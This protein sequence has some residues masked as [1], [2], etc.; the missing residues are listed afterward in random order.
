VRE[1]KQVHLWQKIEH[2][3]AR[4]QQKWV[5]LGK[6]TKTML[7]RYSGQS[8]VERWRTLDNLN[9]NWDTRT[10]MLARFV[11]PNCSVIEFGAGRC[12]LPRY[13]PGGCTYT[14]SDL[15]DRGPGTIICDLN[16]HQL[17]EFPWHDVALF[18][19]VLEYVHDLDRLVAHLTRSCSLIAAS[20][21]ATDYPV[22]Q[23]V[24]TRRRHGWVNDYQTAELE[25]LF[26]HHGFRCIER[27]LWHTHPLFKFENTQR[28]GRCANL[29]LN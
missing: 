25:Q 4:V 3:S 26:Q 6:A 15:V 17:P 14:P 19:G 18:S 20:Y 24:L 21:A 16:A 23:R 10:A 29:I 1:K 5:A 28:A 11:P 13:L 27:Q 12:I 8:D 2:A 22:Q 7:L 9:E